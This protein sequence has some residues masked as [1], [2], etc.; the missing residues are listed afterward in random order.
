MIC[1]LAERV[2]ETSSQVLP[3]TSQTGSEA[4]EEDDEKRVDM[5]NS[6]LSETC[7][8]VEGAP[9]RSDAIIRSSGCNAPTSEFSRSTS[10]TTLNISRIRASD[11]GLSTTTT[12]SGLLDE[13]RTSPQ[14]P[15]SVTTRTPLTVMRS[16]MGWPPTCLAPLG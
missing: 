13:A 15:S 10:S 1:A 12:S 9:G 2:R 3:V 4:S 16:T 8:A 5:G 14:V 6:G 7:P 11:T